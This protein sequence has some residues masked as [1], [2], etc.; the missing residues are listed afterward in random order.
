MVN[1]RL[2]YNTILRLWMFLEILDNYWFFMLLK[3]HPTHAEWK[4]RIVLR[5]YIFL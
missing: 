2:G 5:V 1:P 4:Y 3:I